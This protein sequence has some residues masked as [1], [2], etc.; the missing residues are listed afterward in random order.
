MSVL[1]ALRIFYKNYSVWIILIENS[2]VWIVLIAYF[3][4][5]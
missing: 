1:S 2:Y 4:L 3:I 5:L